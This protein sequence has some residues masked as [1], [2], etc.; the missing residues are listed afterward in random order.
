MAV[1]QYTAR[2]AAG[3]EFSSIY[4]NVE[5]MDSLRKELVKLGYVLVRARRQRVHTVSRGRVR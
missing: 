4:S 2:D 3:N 1:Y 5:S